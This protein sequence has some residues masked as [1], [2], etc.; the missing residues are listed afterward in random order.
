MADSRKTIS[1]GRNCL[2]GTS[3]YH[4]DN[5]YIHRFTRFVQ[6][7]TVDFLRRRKNRKTRA[8]FSV[9]ESGE[10]RPLVANNL[11]HYKFYGNRNLLIEEKNGSGINGIWPW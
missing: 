9:G 1:V 7:Q 6:R 2:A 5:S 8:D 3:L 11:G 4:A 10:H